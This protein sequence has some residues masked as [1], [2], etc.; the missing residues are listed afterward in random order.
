M[1]DILVS[2]LYMYGYN[3][4]ICYNK[5]ILK[6][7]ACCIFE[8]MLRFFITKYPHFYMFLITEA[9]TLTQARPG[10]VIMIPWI[11][12]YC[13]KIWHKFDI[14]NLKSA[15]KSPT[16]QAM[17]LIAN[18]IERLNRTKIALTQSL[19]NV[20]DVINPR[21]DGAKRRARVLIP[22]GYLHPGKRKH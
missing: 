4:Y 10:F 11:I 9:W 15:I 19:I 17:Q 13:Q 2:F 8:L 18:I 16:S 20:W 14:F 12:L 6:M 22:L 3:M 1:K 7:N 21:A 5:C